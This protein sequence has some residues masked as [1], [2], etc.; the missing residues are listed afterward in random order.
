MTKAHDSTGDASPTFRQALGSFIFR[1][2]DGLP[3]VLAVLVASGVLSLLFG[4]AR[5]PQFVNGTLFQRL[6]FDFPVYLDIDREERLF[7]IDSNSRRITCLDHKGRVRWTIE[8]GQRSGGFYES[9]RL[10]A[11]GDGGV[12][13]YNTVYNPSSGDI[14]A[15]EILLYGPDGLLAGPVVRSTEPQET[16]LAFEVRS[17]VL[18]YF[19]Q[20]DGQLRLHAVNLAAPK[21]SPDPA[22][23]ELL[24]S[25]PCTIDFVAVKPFPGDRLIMS[26]RSGRLVLL[27]KK[28]NTQTLDVATGSP[29][30][31]GFLKPWD[32][33]AGA[34]DSIYV[35]DLLRQ[36][37]YRLPSG[38]GASAE[39]VFGMDDVRAAGMDNP[40]F[41]Y[42]AVSKS[43]TLGLVDKFNHSV[44]LKRADGT[45]ECITGGTM[46]GEYQV[47]C[48]VSLSLVGLFLLSASLAIVFLLRRLFAENVSIMV[49]Q[50]SILLPLVVISVV[51]G[52]SRLLIL[53]QDRYDSQVATKLEVVAGLGSRMIDGSLLDRINLASD[54]KGPA[55][56][57]L[58]EQ[59]AAI[60]GSNGAEWNKDLGV[61]VYKV[62]GDRFHMVRSSSSYYGIMFPFGK[63]TRQH[64]AA[65]RSGTISNCTY[66]DEFGGWICG[67]APLRNASGEITGVLEVYHN[68]YFMKELE[69]GF[70]VRLV[71]GILAVVLVVIL[72]LVVVDIILF[73]SLNSLRRASHQVNQ[74]RLG[75]TV[76]ARRRDEIGD[77]SR[78]F[79]TMSVKLKDFFSR[80]EE[81][82]DANSRFV[83]VEFINYLGKDSIADVR[84]GEQKRRQLTLFFADIR[85]FTALSE[86]MTPKENFDFI[87]SYLSVMGPVIRENGGFIDRYLG[88]AIMA[89]FPDSPGQGVHAALRMHEKLRD[90]N[91]ARRADGKM[92][93]DFG[94]GIHTEEVILGVLGEARRLSATVVSDAVDLVNRL[95]ALNKQH[96]TGIILSAACFAGLEPELKELC[97]PAGTVDYDDEALPIYGIVQPKGD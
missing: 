43:G 25:V 3:L 90:F 96:G 60:I 64:L 63:P 19:R 56:T 31:G 57:A 6:G 45:I 11:T 26:D 95:E 8:G 88:D 84:S 93:I 34:D 80:L 12:C 47:L 42:M 91:A 41:E 62:T 67:M 69:N 66:Y 1:F 29:A 2:R 74:G 20:L 65:A 46:A 23:H 72:L 68:L 16:L 89:L 28:G 38:P 58:L 13:V 32:I 92:P 75:I 59:T 51:V 39:A 61:V 10:A 35:L 71:A 15:E 77:L 49:K 22:S 73:L 81:L 7:V 82:R 83:P 54:L 17:G 33:K 37:M 18:Q 94:V 40:V 30:G 70:N 24:M 78:D 76:S 48:I 53:I 79:N 14:E 21:R 9:I 97:Q 50:V 85:S 86:G 5:V 55:H 36:N 52:A 44:W 4:W 87:N 27:D